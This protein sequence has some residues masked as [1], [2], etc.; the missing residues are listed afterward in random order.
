VN[1]SAKRPPADDDA[2]N[3]ARHREQ[4]RLHPQRPRDVEYPAAEREPHCDIRCSSRGAR[5]QQIHQIAAG[6]EERHSHGKR[7]ER[8]RPSM[9]ANEILMERAN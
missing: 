9:V 5:Q 3:T 6:H 8:Q 2:C 1:E 4:Q 7:E